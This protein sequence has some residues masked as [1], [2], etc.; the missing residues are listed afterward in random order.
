MH[1]SYSIMLFLYALLCVAIISTSAVAS[2]GLLDTNPFPFI[3]RNKL[4]RRSF[5]VKPVIAIRSEDILKHYNRPTSGAGSDAASE[6]PA[7][8]I[9]ELGADDGIHPPKLRANS[10]PTRNRPEW[11]PSSPEPK[12]QPETGEPDDTY[13]KVGFDDTA[14]VG[15]RP[16]SPGSELGADD[17]TKSVDGF[18][19]HR[20]KVP[21]ASGASVHPP[22]APQRGGDSVKRLKTQ[23]TQRKLWKLAAQ[24]EQR[25]KLKGLQGL[26][27]QAANRNKPEDQKSSQLAT[28]TGDRPAAGHAPVTGNTKSDVRGSRRNANKKPSA[29]PTV[30]ND[31]QPTA[32]KPAVN[33]GQD[34]NAGGPGRKKKSKK[35]GPPTTEPVVNSGRDANAGGPGK[36]KQSKKTGPPTTEPVAKASGKAGAGSV[37]KPS[38]WGGKKKAV[39]APVANPGGQGPNPN[40]RRG[41]R[42]IQNQNAPP[43]E[44]QPEPKLELPDRRHSI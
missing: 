30:V 35:P 19:I 28:A 27:A 34:A 18:P 15:R 42:R 40:S 26:A 17:E 12:G 13:N 29:R 2:T 7:S 41:R 43:P 25:N 21:P 36:K 5:N 22:G 39:P 8:P 37:T 16:S 1:D 33:S 4:Q 6:G 38:R 20:P 32:E 31:N 44:I 10:S 3:P 24:A 11:K 9:S 23:A 14:S